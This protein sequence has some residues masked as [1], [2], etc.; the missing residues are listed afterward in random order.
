MFWVLTVLL[1]DIVKI[2]DRFLAKQEHEQAPVSVQ[3][4]KV[5]S[6]NTYRFEK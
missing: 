1:Q 6:E 3:V 5:L 2:A 4:A